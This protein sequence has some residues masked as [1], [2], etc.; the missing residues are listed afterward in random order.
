MPRLAR[1][2]LGSPFLHLMVQGVNKEYI[3]DT[4]EYIELYLNLFNKNL[5]KYNITLIA[6][7]MMNNHAHFLIYV[8]DVKDL[9]KF[10][11]KNNLKFAQIYNKKE[12]RTGVLF[13]NRY[14]TEPI[15]DIKYIINCIKYIHENPVKAG[16]VNRCDQYKYSSYNDYKNNT[17]LSQSKIMKKIFGSECDYNQLFNNAF[18]LKQMDIEDDDESIDEYINKAIGEYMK[19]SLD[20]LAE[21]L[22]NRE[23]LKNMFFFMKETCGIKYT[24]IMK[25][26]DITKGSMESLKIKLP[27]FW[28]VS[29]KSSQKSWKKIQGRR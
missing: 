7:C 19:K 17:G 20:N 6:Y 27:W 10:M 29:P 8:E 23:K 21:I 4:N 16:I 13:R 5:T 3:F 2:S 14:Q 15:Y 22:S 11:Q 25:F 18:E 1:K 9:G 12:G 24:E 26:F 28:K